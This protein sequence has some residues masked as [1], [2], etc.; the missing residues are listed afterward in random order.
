MA[1]GYHAP[2]SQYLRIETYEWY[3]KRNMAPG[4]RWEHWARAVYWV[5]KEPAMKLD[6]APVTPNEE[7]NGDVKLV[8]VN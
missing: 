5:T 7:F 3:E 1:R 2:G 8:S 4:L 6:E